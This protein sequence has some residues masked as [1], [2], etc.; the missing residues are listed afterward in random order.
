MSKRHKKMK[1]FAAE[2]GADGA[3]LDPMAFMYADAHPQ[4]GKRPRKSVHGFLHKKTRP[5]RVRL[6][7]LI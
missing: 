3:G 2:T 7:S 6:G 1:M 4:K 5:G